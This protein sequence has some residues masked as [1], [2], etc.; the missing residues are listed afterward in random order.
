MTN[1]RSS[2]RVTLSHVELEEFLSD[3]GQSIE[4]NP[5]GYRE[6]ELS[7]CDNLITPRKMAKDGAYTFRTNSDEEC[8]REF[9]VV[10]HLNSHPLICFEQSIETFGEMS[11]VRCTTNRNQTHPCIDLSLNSCILFLHS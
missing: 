7:E 8:I 2:R 10:R 5:R 1:G 9:C 6:V 3:S 4:V 11:T